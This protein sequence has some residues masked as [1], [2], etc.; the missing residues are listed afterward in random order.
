MKRDITVY[1][2]SAWW[3]DSDPH[4]G[5]VALTA[6][7]AEKAIEDAIESTADDAFNCAD[8]DDENDKEDY[9]DQQAW[10][11]VF[12]ESLRSI[13][14][15]TRERTEVLADLRASGVAYLETP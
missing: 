2:A 8:E 14:E 10:S 15:N 9:I 7:A 1:V 4:T 13:L 11:G 12:P 3:R 5:V 6:E